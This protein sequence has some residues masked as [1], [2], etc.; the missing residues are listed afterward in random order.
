MVS[1]VIPIL[2]CKIKKTQGNKSLL[3]LLILL[4]NI[5]LVGNFIKIHLLTNFYILLLWVVIKLCWEGC[6]KLSIKWFLENHCRFM[7]FGIFLGLQSSRINSL[8]ILFLWLKQLKTSCLIYS[9]FPKISTWQPYWNSRS[10]LLSKWFVLWPLSTIDLFSSIG[11]DPL[12]A[13][14][15]LRLPQFLM[16]FLGKLQKTSSKNKQF[17]MFY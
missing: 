14:I 8:L 1:M 12:R 4:A 13:S 5:F 17:W 7:N 15:W 2:S 9:F 10:R 3:F 6:Q 11:L 16:V